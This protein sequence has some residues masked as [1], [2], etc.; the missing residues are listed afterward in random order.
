MDKRSIST[1]DSRDS[2][3]GP[4]N[5][6]VV[7]LQ[8]SYNVNYEDEIRDAP[9]IDKIE[10][11]ICDRIETGINDGDKFINSRLGLE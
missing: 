1:N 5:S 2:N 7:S 6:C 10:I 8:T 9:E 3:I 4:R 11:I